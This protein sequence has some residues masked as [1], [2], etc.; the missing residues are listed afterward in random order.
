[1]T[2]DNQN[3]GRGGDRNP[4]TH[5]IKTRHGQGRNA[6]YERLG[7]A[8]LNPEDGSLYIKLAG[9]QIVSSGFTAYEIE[10]NGGAQ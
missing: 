8:W 9:T 3:S 5:V 10:E 6:S 2:Y 7:V 4:P 1:M